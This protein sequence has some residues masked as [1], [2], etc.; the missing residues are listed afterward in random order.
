MRI[1]FE[2]RVKLRRLQDEWRCPTL[3]DVLTRVLMD[4]ENET[5]AE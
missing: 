3:N 4:L 2:N 5:N 1:S